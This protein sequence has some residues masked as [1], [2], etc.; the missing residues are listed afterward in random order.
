MMATANR[1]LA[2]ALP[3]PDDRDT[4]AARGMPELH[5]LRHVPAPETHGN[6]KYTR[7]EA[8]RL[9]VSGRRQAIGTGTDHDDIAAVGL[10]AVV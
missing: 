2:G 7:G 4:A 9:E 5:P 10:F 6:A 1:E 3:S 8:R